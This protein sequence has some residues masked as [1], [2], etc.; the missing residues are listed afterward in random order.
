MPSTAYSR[1]RGPALGVPVAH[2]VTLTV[3][4]AVANRCCEPVL[5][6]GKNLK[7]QTGVANRFAMFCEADGLEVLPPE[8]PLS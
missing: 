3:W 1:M 8:P 2:G 5:R 4:Q 6:N 7:W